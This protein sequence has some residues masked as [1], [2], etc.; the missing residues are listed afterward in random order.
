MA[1][2]IIA[3]DFDG[4]L[5]EACWP[6]IGAPKKAVIRYVM[7]QQKQGAKIILWTNRCGEYL[8]NA[9][10][11]C[12]EHGIEFDAVN[13]NLPQMIKAFGN[14]CRKVYADEY[15]DDRAIPL[16][17]DIDDGKAHPRFTRCRRV[18]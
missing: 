15:L 6:A 13:E 5:C 18:R 10:R 2:K 7:E 17:V 9:V 16:P 8:D 1:D 3:V 11:W 4:T 12:K 14:D